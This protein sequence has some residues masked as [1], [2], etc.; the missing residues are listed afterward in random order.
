[1][2]KSE[3]ISKDAKK[4]SK[5]TPRVLLLSVVAVFILSLGLVANFAIPH[6]E[7]HGAGGCAPG[8]TCAVNARVTINSKTYGTTYTVNYD[9]TTKVPGNLPSNPGYAIYNWYTDS[10]FNNV[11]NFANHV[12][13]DMYLYGKWEK[14]GNCTVT[15]NTQGGSAVSSQ[16]VACNSKVSVPAT[17]TKADSSFRGWY[18]DSAATQA[19]D[20]ANTPVRSDI[21]LYAKWTY[22]SEYDCTASNR[23]IGGGTTCTRFYHTNQKVKVTVSAVSLPE[24]TSRVAVAIAEDLSNYQDAYWNFKKGTWNCEPAPDYGY[25]DHTYLI[26]K[27]H[28]S[29]SVVVPVEDK[30]STLFGKYTVQDMY[31]YAW[32]GNNDKIHISYETVD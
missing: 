32:G 4:N 29:F 30:H 25:P 5:K 6:K 15:F 18:T 10:S 12:T 7:A 26:D 19:F 13:S 31:V 27:E 21:T 24:P 22:F 1:M 20:F 16:T 23:L 3:N 9:S 17:P 28:T 2:E 8:G 14:A 11:W